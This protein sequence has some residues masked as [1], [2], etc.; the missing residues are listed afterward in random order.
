MRIIWLQLAVPVIA[1]GLAWAA[2]IINAS[3]DSVYSQA[4][5]ERAENGWKTDNPEHVIA[6]Y[7]IWLVVV[8]GFLALFTGALFVATFAL[9]RTASRDGKKVL[10]QARELFTAERRPWIKLRLEPTGEVRTDGEKAWVKIRFTRSNVGLSPAHN[11]VTKLEKVESSYWPEWF[12]RLKSDVTEAVKE[13]DAF[14][15]GDA[16]SAIFPGDDDYIVHPVQMPLENDGAISVWVFGYV[17]YRSTISGNWH[18]TPF[19]RT[20][21]AEISDDNPNEF[22]GFRIGFSPFSIPPT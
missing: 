21:M 5:Y 15:D 3:V 6:A 7:T 2:T 19:I 16:G 13:G 17:L 11:V 18:A 12:D 1:L 20:F 9:F 4:A 22:K 10:T 8:T 14:G